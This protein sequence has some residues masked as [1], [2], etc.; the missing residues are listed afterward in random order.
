MFTIFMALI[1]TY[2]F[3]NYLYKFCNQVND[4]IGIVWNKAGTHQLFS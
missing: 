2:A 4:K 3:K 1:G